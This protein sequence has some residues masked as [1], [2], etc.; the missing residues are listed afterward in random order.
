MQKPLI[1]CCLSSFSCVPNAEMSQ[2]WWRETIISALILFVII[3]GLNVHVSS[4]D[5]SNVSHSTRRVWMN[6]ETFRGVPVWGPTSL[7][8]LWSRLVS[9]FVSENQNRG[10][11]KSRPSVLVQNLRSSAL[12]F[13]SPPSRARWPAPCLFY[14]NV[15]FFFFQPT[16]KRASAHPGAVLLVSCVFKL[17]I[18]RCSAFHWAMQ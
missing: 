12:W 6:R 1:R 8:P 15:L 17:F 16:V 7:V 2:S 13:W 9:V 14:I 4:N 18:L 11:F 10:L 5:G 3:C